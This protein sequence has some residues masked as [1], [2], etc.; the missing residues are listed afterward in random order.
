MVKLLKNDRNLIKYLSQNYFI[1]EFIIISC[2]YFQDKLKKLSIL[3]QNLSNRMF[4]KTFI[5]IFNHLN[6][7]NLYFIT[8]HIII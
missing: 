5:F 3:N 4:L 7:Y 2:F 1:L 6:L 8:D